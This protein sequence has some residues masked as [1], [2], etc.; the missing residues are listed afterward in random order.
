MIYN[1]RHDRGRT[2]E[3]AERIRREKQVSQGWG[4]GTSENLDLRTEDFV[5]NT[6]SWYELSTTRIATNLSRMKEFRDDD[7]LVLP[8]LPEYGVVSLHVVDGDFPCCYE[9]DSSDS[10]DQNHRIKVKRSFGM[11]G[12]LPVQSVRLGLIQYHAK[13]PWLRLPV[14]P[15]PQFELIFAELVKKMS[16]EPAGQTQYGPSELDDFLRDMACSVDAVVTEKMRKMRAGG[17]AISFEALCEK[18]VLGSGYGYE[19]VDRNKY[20][21]E[22]G[23]LDLI[24]KREG[25]D[26]ETGDVTLC[27][28]IKKHEGETGEAAVDQV[29]GMLPDWPDAHG[30]VMSAADGFTED[31]KKKARVHG[32]KLLNRRDIFRLLMP[33]LPD[34]FDPEGGE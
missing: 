30:C 31:A 10:T 13:L 22:G 9:Y 3:I 7:I 26:F 21:R 1:I 24:C 25:R 14:L 2:Q 33:Q 27:I 15:M 5:K 4:G 23:D 6:C 17:G 12:E 19:V 11:N 28:Q 16:A 29:I 18:I 20:N 8:H 34:Y 32:I